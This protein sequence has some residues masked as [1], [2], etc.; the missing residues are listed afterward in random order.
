MCL[1]PL[2]NY[3]TDSIAYK[4][5]VTEF[6]CGA[7]P[8]CLRKRASQWVLRAVYEARVSFGFMATFTYDNFLRDKKGKILRSSSGVPLETPVN[9]YLRVNKR[10]V[11]LFIKRLRK[12]F[13]D[14]KIKYIACAEYGSRTHRAHYHMLIFGLPLNDVRPYK[15]SKRGNQIYWSDTLYKLWNHGI[16]TVDSLNIRAAAAMYCTKYC[17]KSRSL[18]TFILCSQHIGYDELYK[19]FNGRNYMIEGREFTVPRFIWERYISEKYCFNSDGLLFSSKYINKSDSRY[20]LGVQL[21]A[22]Y[23]YLRDH[24]PVYISYLDYWSR[25]GLEFDQHKIPVRQRILDLNDKKLHNYKLAALSCYDRKRLSGEFELA[26]GSRS[27]VS[28]LLRECYLRQR[29]LGI[30]FPLNIENSHLPLLSRPNTASDTRDQMWH[31]FF[32]D[33]PKKRCDYYRDVYD[34]HDMISNCYIYNLNH[35]FPTE[36]YEKLISSFTRSNELT[37]NEEF[38]ILNKVEEI[39]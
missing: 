15:K 16:V 24:D 18:D 32:K 14:N 6:D 27:G 26:P 21:R 36:Y 3:N 9:P 13:P 30:Y 1:F 7:C 28:S 23:R 17:A 39:F 11:Q 19:D 8:E 37:P 34:E 25:R 2:P 38:E 35:G 20:E 12:H 10:D 5:G 4:K 33:I 31:N 22:G 29:R